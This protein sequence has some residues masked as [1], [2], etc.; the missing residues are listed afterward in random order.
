MKYHVIT[1]IHFFAIK[2]ENF[3]YPQYFSSNNFSSQHLQLALS[4]NIRVKV[5]RNYQKFGQYRN[6]CHN[7]PE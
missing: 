2:I 5:G 7:A 3:R 1:S 4:A 6:I